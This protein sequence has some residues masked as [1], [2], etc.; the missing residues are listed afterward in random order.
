MKR[1]LLSLAFVAI[2][3]SSLALGYTYYSE[4]HRPG[5]LEKPKMQVVGLQAGTKLVAPDTQVVYEREYQRCHHTVISGFQDTSKIIGRDIEALRQIFPSK[6][7]YTISFSDNVLIIH[8]LVNDWCP[9]EKGYFRLKE[10]QGRVAVYT[11]EAENE[12]L[13]RVTA[14][15]MNLLP[16]EIQQAINNGEY[17][18][19]DQATLNDTLE[20]LDEYL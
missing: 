15:R 13:T 20:N 10:Y 3:I 12:V 16:P 2:A 11:G 5:I 6:D 14:I 7:G 8:Q 9:Q 17:H 4:Y 18:F 1:T 19:N